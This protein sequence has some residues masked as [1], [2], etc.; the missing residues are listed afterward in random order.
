MG[1]RISFPPEFEIAHC[2]RCA[3][4]P[5]L[6][7]FGASARGN[8]SELLTKRGF[9]RKLAK[10]NGAGAYIRTFSWGPDVLATASVCIHAENVL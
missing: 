9:E 2:D 10:P 7:R 4:A 6:A 8:Y 3:P 5:G 1:P